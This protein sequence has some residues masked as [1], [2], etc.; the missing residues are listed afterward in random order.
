MRFALLVIASLAISLT[1]AA[2]GADWTDA[3]FPERTYRLRHRGQGVEG[4]PFV[5]ADQ[6]DRPGDP[7][8]LLEDQMRLHRREGRRPRRPAG[9]PDGP[10]RR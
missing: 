3:V 9:H 2:E 10:S 1:S 6:Y 8:R 4:P 5:Q 7:H